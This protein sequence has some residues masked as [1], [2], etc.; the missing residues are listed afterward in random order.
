MV[1]PPSW[2]RMGSVRRSIR[3]AP[4]SVRITR[5]TLE[6]AIFSSVA[7][8]GWLFAAGG[9]PQ[10]MSSKP[11]AKTKD[12]ALSRRG[13][14]CMG[15]EISFDR[16]WWSVGGNAGRYGRFGCRERHRWTRIL[17]A[18]Q[19]GFGTRPE[20]QGQRGNDEQADQRRTEQAA[21]Y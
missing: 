17:R 13:M 11:A 9:E 19:F 21:Q 8:L 16:R 12:I 14:R 18:G 7:G 15:L 5:A 4:C 1:E 2:M 20:V 10:A 6:P 3:L